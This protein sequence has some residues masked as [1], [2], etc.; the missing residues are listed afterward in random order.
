M[1]NSLGIFN[2]CIDYYFCHII[3]VSRNKCY[4]N[5]IKQIYIFGD[6]LS[7][8]SSILDMKTPFVSQREN[9]LQ[10]QRDGEVGRRGACSEKVTFTLDFN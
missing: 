7:D 2:S 9:V 8:M 6:V 10:T 1:A 5:V 4:E 3:R